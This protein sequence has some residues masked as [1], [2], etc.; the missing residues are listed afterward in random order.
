MSE[1][2]VQKKILD[3]LKANN[4]W[5]FKTITCNRSGIMDI[6]GCTPTGQFIGVEVKYGDN[7]C[8]K[9]QSWNILEVAKRGGIAFAA[10]SLDDVRSKLES[11]HRRQ[12]S[13]ADGSN[14]TTRGVNRK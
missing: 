1:S 2:K 14:A 5:V 8:S 4:Y 7:K 6:V 3:W 13:G 10:W 9:L 11:L 12:T